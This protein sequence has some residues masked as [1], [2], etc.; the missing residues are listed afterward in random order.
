MVQKGLRDAP[1][2]DIVPAL[3]AAGAANER[4]ALESQ[5]AG[6]QAQSRVA[7]AERQQLLSA[8]GAMPPAELADA[9]HQ[10]DEDGDPLVGELGVTLGG[11]SDEDLHAQVLSAIKRSERAADAALQLF[12]HDGEEMSYD[13]EEEDFGVEDNWARRRQA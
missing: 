5:I 6:M 10:A 13:D 7:D 8:V 2:L 9:L 11:A 12:P 3:Q 4:A 1:S